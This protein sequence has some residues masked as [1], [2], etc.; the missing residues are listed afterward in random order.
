M[1][2]YLYICLCILFIYLLLSIKFHNGARDTGYE[3]V[4]R[5]IVVFQFY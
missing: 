3:T 4:Y 2:I 1:F 5:K